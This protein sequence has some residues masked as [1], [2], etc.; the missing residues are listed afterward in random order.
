MEMVQTQGGLP[1]LCLGWPAA[2]ILKPPTPCPI[3]N[4]TLPCGWGANSPQM[5]AQ[6]LPGSRRK[7]LPGH[8]GHWVPSRGAHCPC[9]QRT[10]QGP[11][12]SCRPVLLA[13]LGCS[14]CWG[15]SPSPRTLGTLV[16]VSLGLTPYNRLK[17]RIHKI[18]AVI[19]DSVWWKRSRPEIGMLTLFQR[20]R[21][22]SPRSPPPNG[23]CR[24]PKP[25]SPE[26][27]A[28][29]PPTGICPASRPAPGPLRGPAQG[30]PH[31]TLSASA[32]GPTPV[33]GIEAPGGAA[34][35]SR[36]APAGQAW[37]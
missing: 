27:R 20:P 23:A 21:A 28:A 31:L 3:H 11:V 9:P 12:S 35:G 7:A 13:G 8:A 2:E 37:R 25:Q 32:L 10:L 19:H 17:H 15:A 4:P 33:L 26:P 14:L 18:W 1:S 34:L 22:V 5:S 36:A 6:V 24:P 30:T 16:T 29:T